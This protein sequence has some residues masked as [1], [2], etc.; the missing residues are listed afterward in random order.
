MSKKSNTNNSDN[1][2]Y[3]YNYK[4]Y[5]CSKSRND[6]YYINIGSSSE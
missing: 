2:I 4:K 5:I 1:S 3:E 6:G